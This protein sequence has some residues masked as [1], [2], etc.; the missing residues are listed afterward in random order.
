M[1]L[2]FIAAPGGGKS[3]QAK[4]LERDFGWKRLST[5]EILRAKATEQDSVGEEVKKLLD[6]GELIPDSVVNRI[7]TDILPEDDW[8]LDG[9]PRTLDQVDYLDDLN[10]PD[11]VIYLDASDDV[12]YKRL[13]SIRK[14]EDDTEKLIAKRLSIFYKETKP[15]I[16]EYKSQEKLLTINA[17]GTIEQ[18]DTAIR[19]ALKGE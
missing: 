14:R 15:L 18:V 8:M 12:I 1:K 5:G 17:D 13:L 2:I 19:E 10:P 9:Y 11:K 4:L 6:N 16:E 3:S 7:V